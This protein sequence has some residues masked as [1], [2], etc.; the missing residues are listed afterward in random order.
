MLSK[1]D[2]S[3]EKYHALKAL[4]AAESC[5]KIL[6]SN[7][8]TVSGKIRSAL[9]KIPLI[10]IELNLAGLDVPFDERGYFK[11]I[12]IME[13]MNSYPYP[14]SDCH[15]VSEIHW[16]KKHNMLSEL[17]EYCSSVIANCGKVRLS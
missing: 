14:S 5:L 8:E 12:D 11:E 17:V 16:M 4:E 10:Q 7:F 13:N 6:A 15:K 2:Q 1:K 3:M 9:R